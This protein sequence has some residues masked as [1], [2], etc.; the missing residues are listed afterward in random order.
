[1]WGGDHL[2]CWWEDELVRCCKDAGEGTHVHCWREDEFM[3]PVWK[4]IRGILKTLKPDLAHGP[5]APFL[6]T[7]LQDSKAAC[8]RYPY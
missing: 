6:D 1:M 8:Q 2:H 7:H 4:S 5:A 3:L